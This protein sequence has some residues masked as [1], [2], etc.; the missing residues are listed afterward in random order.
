MLVTEL[1]LS[2]FCGKYCLFREH[3]SWT[4]PWVFDVNV[5]NNSVINTYYSGS[6]AYTILSFHCISSL[7][8]ILGTFPS[9]SILFILPGTSPIDN[10]LGTLVLWSLHLLCMEHS[11]LLFIQMTR[12]SFGWWIHGVVRRVPRFQFQ[13]PECPC[14]A[15]PFSR[16]I[17][18]CLPGSNTIGGAFLG[19]VLCI[20]NRLKMGSRSA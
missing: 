5:S 20:F 8:T 1:Q 7:W 19:L 11:P 15:M 16:R 14:G 4:N 10:I 13:L 3:I 6:H 17:P 9:F 18:S 12:H 2:R